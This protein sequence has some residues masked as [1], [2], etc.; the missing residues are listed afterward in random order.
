MHRV[1]EKKKTNP[2]L[3][4]TIFFLISG[5]TSFVIKTV[6]FTPKE[7]IVKIVGE[8]PTTTIKTTIDASELKP[9]NTEEKNLNY[10]NNWKAFISIGTLHK[11]VD[12]IVTPENRITEINIPI[13]NK[14]DYPI[15]SATIKVLFMNPSNTNSVESRTFEVTNILASSH[16]SYRS[17]DS[18]VKGVNIICEIIKIHSGNFDFCYD[19][20]LLIDSQSKGGFS[21]NPADPWHCK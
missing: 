17:P 21:G 14:T 15:E 7:T 1:K 11:D 3:L 6:Y 16:I 18:N 10:R 8:R 12:Y 20:D 13:I 2:F 5:I 4:I 9:S 19:V